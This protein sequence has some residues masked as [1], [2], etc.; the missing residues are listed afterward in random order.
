MV[1]L[2][3]MACGLPLVAFDAPC[4]PKDIV[5]DGVNGLLVETGNIEK[6]TEKIIFLIESEM[7]RKYMGKEAKRMAMN[8]RE[9]RIMEQWIHLLE[10]LK[11][12]N[13]CSIGN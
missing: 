10:E 5:T 6:L 11:N 4:G 9:D 13:S 7:A 2:E 1:L 8:Y 12:E 3:A